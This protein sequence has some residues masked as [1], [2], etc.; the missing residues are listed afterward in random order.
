MDACVCTS[1]LL[2]IGPVF[3]GM[4][5]LKVSIAR[6]RFSGAEDIGQAR[7]L[8]CAVSAPMRELSEIPR[9]FRVPASAVR[10]RAG[11]KGGGS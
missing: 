10:N 7:Q 4:D 8:S 11:E 3:N 1:E 9:E 5:P 2:L 6:V